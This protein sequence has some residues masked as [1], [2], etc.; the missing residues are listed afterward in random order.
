MLWRWWTKEQRSIRQQKEMTAHRLV[1][2][3]RQIRPWSIHPNNTYSFRSVLLIWFHFVLCLF[4]IPVWNYPPAS[5]AVVPGWAS[6]KLSLAGAATSIFF[7]GARRTFCRDKH[8]FETC[9]KLLSRQKLY[10]WQLP[11]IILNGGC[12]KGVFQLSIINCLTL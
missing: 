4:S 3:S 7:F 5:V 9:M 10:L 8:V 11:P 6:F 2:N 12:Q 1:Q